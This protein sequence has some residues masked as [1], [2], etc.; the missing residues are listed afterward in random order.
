MYN[1][2]IEKTASKAMTALEAACF[3][4]VNRQIGLSNEDISGEILDKVDNLCHFNKIPGL[5]HG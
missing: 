2:L 3:Y 5:I 4:Y 1:Y